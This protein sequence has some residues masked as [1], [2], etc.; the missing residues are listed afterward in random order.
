MS[1]TVKLTD[2]IFEIFS[3]QI[4]WITHIFKGFIVLGIFPSIAA[5]FAVVRH[6][7]LKREV[8]SLYNIFK[9]YYKE[10]F[11]T[12]NILGW[13]FSSITFI[14]I[15][16]FIYTAYYPEQIQIIMYAAVIFMAIIL[17]IVWAYLFPAIV[18]YKL[19]VY[20]LF[21]VVLKAGFSSL[22]GIIFQL[23]SAVI[24]FVIIFK[25]PGLVLIFGIIPFAFTQTAISIKVFHELN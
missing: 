22:K 13:F 19:S 6:W 12:A 8:E 5:V 4:L 23:I 3:L 21:L 17:L 2:W 14:V 9:Q 20:E 10:N 1:K 11:K 7:L 25:L 24:I 15:M 16:N 18:H